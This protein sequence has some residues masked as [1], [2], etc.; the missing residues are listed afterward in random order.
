MAGCP[1]GWTAGSPSVEDTP[2]QRRH[3]LEAPL[4]LGDDSSGQAPEH[5][6]S[7]PSLTQDSFPFHVHRP[8]GSAKPGRRGLVVAHL[9]APTDTAH[10]ITGLSLLSPLFPMPSHHDRGSLTTFPRLGRGWGAGVPGWESTLRSGSWPRC[11]GQPQLA[12]PCPV[13]IPGWWARSMAPLWVF[14]SQGPPTPVLRSSTALKDSSLLLAA[15]NGQHTLRPSPRGISP[16]DTS[17]FSA[18]LVWDALGISTQAP[19]GPGDGVYRARTSWPLFRVW[20]G[21]KPGL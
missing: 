21:G 11:T 3:A 15:G 2:G 13:C 4:L 16:G 12:R 17:P 6:N 14:Y 9:G 19:C 18:S 20:A 8:V 5:S 10:L 1:G 7:A